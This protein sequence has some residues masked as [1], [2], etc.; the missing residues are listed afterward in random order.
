MK[1]GEKMQFIDELQQK[2]EQM[3]KHHI[4]LCIIFDDFERRI[5]IY[6]P[7]SGDQSVA[8]IMSEPLDVIISC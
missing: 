1:V 6:F 5:L 3:A 4:Y 2:N 7:A 8:A